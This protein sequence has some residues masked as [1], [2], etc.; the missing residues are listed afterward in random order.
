MFGKLSWTV[1]IFV[2]LS[3]FGGVN[4]VVFTSARLFLTGAQ[5]G[6]LPECFSHIHIN[7]RTPIPGL[8]F[9]VRNKIKTLKQR[10]NCKIC[11]RENDYGKL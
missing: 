5:N 10:K 9:C 3:T 2:A 6:H 7:E 1:P 4:G 11:M 8:I